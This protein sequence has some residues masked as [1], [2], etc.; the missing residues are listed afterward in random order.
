MT[1]K[2]RPES[3]PTGDPA[4]DELRKTGTERACFGDADERT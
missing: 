3:A 2:K 4:F 1:S